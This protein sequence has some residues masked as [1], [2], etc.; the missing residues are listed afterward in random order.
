MQRVINEKFP[1]MLKIG[2]E[3]RWKK[4]EKFIIS[5]ILLV[6]YIVVV[7]LLLYFVN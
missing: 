3:N 5:T 7:S 6:V 1:S 2:K 4:F